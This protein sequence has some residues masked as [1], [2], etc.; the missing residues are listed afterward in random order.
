MQSAQILRNGPY[1][2]LRRNDEGCSATPQMDF[3]RSRQVGETH[4]K[5][6]QSLNSTILM[7]MEKH[8]LWLML[9]RILKNRGALSRRLIERFS[10]PGTLFSASMEELCH[11]EGVT[12][13]VA[14]EI[15]STRPPGGDIRDEIKKIEDSGCRVVPLK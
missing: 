8:Y 10:D 12:E 7:T 15:K 1:L 3:L 13:D 14:A 2:Y 11:V 9:A 5:A 6:I 4:L